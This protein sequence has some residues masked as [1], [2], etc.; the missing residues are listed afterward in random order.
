L[1]HEKQPAVALLQYA[2]MIYIPSNKVPAASTIKATR[3]IQGANAVIEATKKPIKAITASA[4][5]T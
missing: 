3:R 1:E 4:T 2:D 5:A